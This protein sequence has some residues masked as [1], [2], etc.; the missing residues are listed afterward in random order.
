[1]VLC[2]NRTP[3]GVNATDRRVTEIERSA[4]D[5]LGRSPDLVLVRVAE[6]G[7]NGGTVRVD[8]APLSDAIVAHVREPARLAA[9]SAKLEHA[10]GTLIGD[11]GQRLARERI[12]LEAGEADVAAMGAS[13]AEVR[14]ARDRSIEAVER[15]NA[16]LDAQLR[17]A[18]A[19]AVENLEKRI[20]REIDDSNKWLGPEECAEWIGVHVMPL[21]VETAAAQLEQI[22]AEELE[23]LDRE[24]DELASGAVGALEKQA[25]VRTDAPAR[26][27]RNLAAGLAKRAAGE[28]AGQALHGLGGVGGLAAGAGNLA[29]MAVKRLAGL[30]GKT[31]GREVYRVIGR[32]FTKRFVAA[33]SAV[34]S[35]AVEAGLYVHEV[36]TW[37][38]DQKAAVSKALEEWCEEVTKEVYD[39]QL[40]AIGRAN[41]AGVCAVFQGLLDEHDAALRSRVAGAAERALRL[42]ALDVRLHALE[43]RLRANDG[44]D[45]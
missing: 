43:A 17:P 27:A 12:V 20:G 5:S 13:I 28:A 39:K 26:L 25:A 2:V 22:I 4:A 23:S 14:T 18:I 33:A 11:A 40:P 44:K 3:R 6:P 19:R 16:R 45:P 10:V 1:M 42:E 38:R 41:M 34:L 9:I 37:Q 7:A 24:L 31:L 29:K 35:A 36:K 15:S 32:L 30:F 21:S 8:T